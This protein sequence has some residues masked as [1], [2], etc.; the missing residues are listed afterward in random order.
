MLQTWIKATIVPKTRH[1]VILLR[2]VKKK[3]KKKKRHTYDN[4]MRIIKVSLKALTLK[5]RKN[6]NKLN[7]QNLS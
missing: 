5:T 1:F 2:F 3:K 4:N 7:D 6:I